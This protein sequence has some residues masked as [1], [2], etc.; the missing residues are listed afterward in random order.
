M[1][2]SEFYSW[3]VFTLLI[4][5]AIF[6]AVFVVLQ[7]VKDAPKGR[8]VASVLKLYTLLYVP[9]LL[10]SLPFDSGLLAP[11]AVVLGSGVGLGV[12]VGSVFS[13][14]RGI[15]RWIK[16]L[17]AEEE[18]GLAE[19]LQSQLAEEKDQSRIRV[20]NEEGKRPFR[21]HIWQKVRDVVLARVAQFYL[22][23]QRER[24]RAEKRRRAKEQLR[25]HK[26]QL[27]EQQRR[28]NEQ[29]WTEKRRQEQEEAIKSFLELM[30]GGEKRLERRSRS[31]PQPV[32]IEVVTRDGGKCRRC[33]STQDLQYDRIVP[34]SRGG[35]QHR[36]E[37]HPAP[38]RQ[39]Q[40]PQEQPQHR[41]VQTL[42]SGV[43]GETVSENSEQAPFRGPLRLQ[44]GAKRHL[45][46]RLTLPRNVPFDPH[47]DFPETVSG[48]I[49]LGTSPRDDVPR[50]S[51]E[52]ET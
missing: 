11:I 39:V 30:R 5:S 6:L 47:S 14:V 40:Q 8:R 15:I 22:F 44:N 26:R 21:R 1:Y 42:F 12:M 9:L 19:E 34:N 4:A 43:R 25:A 49:I 41:L 36:R 50:S 29:R 33:G 24:L 45:Y 3:L 37:Q 13:V 35:Q 7:W 20:R 51:T 10:L 18:Q 48:R 2:T 32:K 23:W 52:P 17:R 28:A 38:L 16:R 31:I 27:E 46:G